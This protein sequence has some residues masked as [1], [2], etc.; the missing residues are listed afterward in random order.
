LFQVAKIK[1]KP[2]EGGPWQ[3]EQ[4]LAQLVVGRVSAD[5]RPA[6]AACGQ[7]QQGQAEPGQVS[8]AEE[9]RQAAAPLAP[10]SPP[11]RQLRVLADR[12]GERHGDGLLRLQRAE[13][14]RG[15]G[16]V[17]G[18]GPRLPR[19][20]PP[21]HPHRLAQGGGGGRRR[22]DGRLRV[23]R[24]QGGDGKRQRGGGHFADAGRRGGHR[25]D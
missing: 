12:N 18:H 4:R 14:E 20:D 2:S 6:D 11:G 8:A 25:R 5:A 3:N 22:R 1:H 23:R 7:G 10:P 24:Q 21:G 15:A 16:F 19:L 17:P 9:G 13:R